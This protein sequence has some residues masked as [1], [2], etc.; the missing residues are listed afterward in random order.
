METYGGVGPRRMQ[1]QYYDSLLSAYTPAEV[2]SQLA[3]A[4][5][6][7]LRVEKVTDRHMDIFGRL[8]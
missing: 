6:D 8:P 2:R 1:E 3:R 4:G 7:M 5:L